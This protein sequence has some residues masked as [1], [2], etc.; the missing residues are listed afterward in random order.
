MS[1]PLLPL[2]QTAISDCRNHSTQFPGAD[3]AIGAYLTRYAN[4]LLCAEIEKVVNGLIRQRLAQG[5]SDS[6]TL[7]FFGFVSP[8]DD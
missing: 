8:G 4:G 3:P 1:V 7:S 6:A 2:T 5:C